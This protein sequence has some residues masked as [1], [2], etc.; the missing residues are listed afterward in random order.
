MVNLANALLYIGNMLIA[1]EI[2]GEIG[3]LQTL[4]NLL[5]ARMIPLALSKLMHP[6]TK[7]NFIKVFFSFLLILAV[8]TLIMGSLV[9]LPIMVAYFI[10]RTLIWLNLIL[11]KLL[12]WVIEPWKEI[13]FVGVR[14]AIKGKPI[15]I[16]PTDRNL[17][18]IAGEHKVRFIALFGVI[19]LTAGFI[20]QIIN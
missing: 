9:F 8:I 16:K 5:F 2:V 6:E 15:K 20:L 7:S 10:G 19:F 14:S 3:Y 13:Y 11:N 17:W 1:F 18:K 12:L 4:F